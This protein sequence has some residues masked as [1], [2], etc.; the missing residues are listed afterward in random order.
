M[1]RYTTPKSRAVEINWLGH[2]SKGIKDIDYL[3]DEVDKFADAT[4]GY[5]AEI[6]KIAI[7]YHETKNKRKIKT[8]A[9]PQTSVKKAAVIRAV[10]KVSKKYL[11]R[12]NV[13][14]KKK[15]RKK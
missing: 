6:D 8:P 14:N 10:E 5:L 7:V 15:A 9:K 1:S 4:K 3:L 12:K 11:Q 13:V 2:D